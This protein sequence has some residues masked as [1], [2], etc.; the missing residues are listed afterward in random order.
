VGVA[1]AHTTLIAS[2]PGK[3]AVVKIAPTT[4]TLKFEDPLLTLKGHAI[5]KVALVDPH[6]KKIALSSVL[7]TGAVVTAHIAAP[8][9]EAGKYQVSYRVSAQDGHIVTGSYFFT[10]QR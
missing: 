9:T 1:Y 3:G 7:V 8:L 10:L 2:Q 5:N 4:I 6:S